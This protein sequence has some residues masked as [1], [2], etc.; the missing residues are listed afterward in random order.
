MREGDLA[1]ATQCLDLSELSVTQRELAPIM[2]GKLW[3]VMIRTEWIPESQIPDDSD[4]DSFDLLAR[5]AGRV[6]LDRQ[7]TPPREGAWLFT[8]RTVAKIETLYDTMERQPIHPSWAEHGVSPSAR[9]ISP[10]ALPALFIREYWVPS[11]LRHDFLRIELWQWLGV[12]LL[13]VLGPL[14][15]VCVS[16]VAAPIG[17]RILSTRDVAMLPSTVRRSLMPLAMLAMLGVWWGGL[18]LL[19][20]PQVMVMWAYWLLRIV[21]TFFSVLAAYRLIDLVMTYSAARAAGSASRLDDVVVPLMDKTL[22]V[23]AVALG[24]IFLLNVIFGIDAWRLVAGLGVGGLAI[25]FAAQ[26][27][28]KN[29]FGSINVVLDRPF[30]VGDWVIVGGV[31]GM[32]DSVG[33]RSTRIRT[34]YKSQVTIPNSEIMNAT[35]DNMQRRPL[36]R[37]KA[38]IGVTYDTKPEALEAF[39][40]GIRELIRQHPVTHKETFYV[41]VNELGDSSIDILL[42]CFLEARTWEIELRERQRLIVDMVRLANSLGVEFAF[43]TRHAA[44]V[45]RGGQRRTHGPHPGQGAGRTLARSRKRGGHC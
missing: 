24:L 5:T 30:Q 42:Y 6:E 23:M 31:E 44:H 26:D 38:M 28:I 33:L 16:V 34:F 43:P 11:A 4:G 37:F 12:L 7:W 45:F 1:R 10:A 27:T 18:Q 2:A 36:R 17:R 8:S 13:L 21:M 32:V 15:R 20:L 14:A 41:Y 3:L 9:A 19:D 29:F 40:E 22:K 39:T 25:A 35:I